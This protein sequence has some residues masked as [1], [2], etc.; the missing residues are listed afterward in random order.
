MR[1]KKYTFFIEVDIDCDLYRKPMQST[2][3]K[4][5]DRNIRSS[6]YI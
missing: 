2:K 4:L 1:L 5:K 6:I 3:N